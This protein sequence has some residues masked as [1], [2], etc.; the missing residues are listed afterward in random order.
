M[1]DGHNI[2][3]VLLELLGQTAEARRAQGK[4]GAGNP[5]VKH[6]SLNRAAVVATVGA[7]EAFS[8]DLAVTAQALD[9]QA[10]PPTAW[11]K[12]T[13]GGGMVQTPTPEN[14]RKMFWTFFRFDPTANWEWA[15]EVSPSELGPG[16]NWRGPVHRY[17]GRDTSKFLNAMVSAR[18][19]FAH[20]DKSQ[21][22]SGFP[23]IVT[24]TPGGKISIHSHHA[25]NALSVLL[26]M[27]ILTTHGLSDH[28][29]LQGQFRWSRAMDDADWARRLKDTTAG[30]LAAKA[31]RNSPTL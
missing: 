22:S 31:W 19:G 13:G 24:L 30:A 2:E 5:G 9:P 15:V 26:Q 11:Y 17:T 27:A 7:L 3:Q 16:S 25:S 4:T 20:Q 29:Q 18:H 14:L 21:S 6:P 12:I 10:N 23:G 28:L 8:E 1:R